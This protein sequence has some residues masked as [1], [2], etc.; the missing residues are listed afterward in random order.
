[1]ELP[2]KKMLQNQRLIYWAS[3]GML[4]VFGMVVYYLI[5]NGSL[6]KADYSLAVL[7]QMIILVLVPASFAA[8]YFIFKMAVQKIDKKQPLR[9]KLN[10]YFTLVIVRSAILEAPGLFCCVAAFLTHEVLFL[11][12]V[13]IILFVFNILRPTPATIA[14]ELGLSPSEKKEVDA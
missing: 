3:P 12:A 8:A 2:I 5:N 4:F 1:M 11:A 13:P 10:R 7:F 9:Q 6:G 14:E